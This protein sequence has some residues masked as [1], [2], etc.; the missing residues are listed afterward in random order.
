[1]A[2]ILSIPLPTGR[3]PLAHYGDAAIDAG[4]GGV[5]MKVGGMLGL[6]QNRKNLI[7]K[8]GSAARGMI[9]DYGEGAAARARSRADQC[10][11][12]SRDFKHWDNVAKVIG[13]MSE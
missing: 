4:E 10:A 3:V 7:A 2:L 6:F 8:Y 13:Y 11:P 12:G 5:L 1:M 9:A